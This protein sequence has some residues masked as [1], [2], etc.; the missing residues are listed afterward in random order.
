MIES[1]EVASGVHRLGSTRVNWYVIVDGDAVTIV[2]T[3]FPGHW[4]MLVSG[5]ER[6]GR[7][8]GDVAGVV[9]THSHVDHTGCAR[10]CSRR[11]AMDRVADLLTEAGSRDCGGVLA[12]ERVKVGSS[13][14]RVGVDLDP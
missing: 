11:P 14:V 3:G 2:D 1:S 6:L 9:L 4:R 7:G 5:L 8:L 12:D 10:A 13:R